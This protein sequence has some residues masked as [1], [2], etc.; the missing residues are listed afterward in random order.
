[1]VCRRCIMTVEQVFANNGIEVVNVELGTVTL[2]KPLDPEKSSS[3]RKQLEKL[4][5]EVLDDK[6]MRIIEQIRIGVIEYVRNPELQEKQN[7]S[8]FLCDKCLRDYS[9]LSKLFSEIN[10]TSIEKY[11]IA[12]RV[13][14]VKELLFYDELTVSEIADRLHYSSVAHLSA[15][16]RTVTGLTPTKFK[17]LKGSKTTSLD[18]I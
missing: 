7:L 4:G 2:P 3:L 8:E 17:Q 14:Y 9:A 6:R 10:G 13:E 1:M 11:Y 15:Q 18:E 16:F 5:F 12:Q